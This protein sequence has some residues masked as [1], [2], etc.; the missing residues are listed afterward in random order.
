MSEDKKNYH[1]TLSDRIAIEQGLYDGKSFRA[2][3]GVIGKDPSTVSKEIKR[4]VGTYDYKKEENN[5][6]F[7]RNCRNK[8]LCSSCYD[9]LC[10]E[11][12]TVDCTKKCNRFQPAFC[13][14]LLTPPYTCNA[15]KYKVQC[16]LDK[17]YYRAKEAQRQYEKTLVN[18][19]KGIN[20]T[21]QEL[22]ELNDLVSPLL[23]QRQPISHIF[24]YHKDELG[25]SK[26]TLYNYIEAGVL[27]AKVMDLPRRVRY[28]K[29]KKHVKKTNPSPKNYVY[30]SN[31]T[32]RDFENY[33]KDNA[34]VEVVEMDTVKG[35]QKSGKCLLTMMFRSSRL[36]LIF[37]LQTCTSAEVVRVFDE[38]TRGLGVNLFSK[39]FP[40]ILT[41]NG[42]E[43]KRP[44]ELEYTLDGCK[45][46]NIFYCDPNN[47]NQKARLERN[48]EYIRYIIPKGRS[49]FRL[50]PED[51]TLIM[52]HINSVSRDSLNG[53]TP[54]EV[55]S[56][57]VNRKVLEQLNL[58]QIQPDEIKLHPTLIKK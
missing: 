48:H 35:T 51:V 2:I 7:A 38:L 33:L 49:M 22:R 10:K 17:R 36:M 5:C 6:K 37:L 41:D 21:P 14:R 53:H 31:R 24:N 54:F 19:R 40:V 8:H 43:F 27:D 57:L 15:C 45:R 55:A 58:S 32:Y 34:E 30:R 39:T 11:C 47:S 4:V 1:M 28:K 50:E 18:S 29:R 13:E 44:K 16:H 20:K 42:S 26:R 3:A 56:M 23:L 12:L 25:I 52:N 9:G 46:T